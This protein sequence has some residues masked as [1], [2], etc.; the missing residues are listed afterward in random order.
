MMLE[1]LSGAISRLF[2]DFK[3]QSEGGHSDPD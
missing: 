1:D 2:Y 3:P